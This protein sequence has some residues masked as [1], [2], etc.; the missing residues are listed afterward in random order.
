[1]D[2]YAQFAQFYDSLPVYLAREDVRFYVEEAKASGGP[3]LELGCGSGRVL[4]PVAQAGIAVTGLDPSP[5]MLE[6]CRQR[7][8]KEGLTAELVSGDMR[9]FSLGRRFPLITIPFRPFQHL[10]EVDDQIACL[11]AVREHLALG[12]KL[13][14]DVFDPNLKMLAAES[15]IEVPVSE[16]DLPDGRHARL[17]YCRREHDRIRQVLNIEMIGEVD[18]QRHVSS[19]W[20]RYNFRW[21]MEHL[22]ARCGFRIEHLYGDFSRHPVSDGTGD[23]IFVTTDEHR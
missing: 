21:E 12:G 11:A 5:S 7:L 8:A 2:P 17:S 1:V 19:L 18:G 22:L 20:L 13:I 10:L 3:V 14:F 4:V 23:L 9:R 15:G 16:F 6:L